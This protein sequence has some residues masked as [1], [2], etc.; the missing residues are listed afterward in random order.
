ML[1]EAGKCS[2]LSKIM[3]GTKKLVQELRKLNTPTTATPGAARRLHIAD[4]VTTALC[5]ASTIGRTGYQEK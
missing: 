3:N 4:A 1:T 5:S 2:G